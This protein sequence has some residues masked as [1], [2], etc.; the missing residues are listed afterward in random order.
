MSEYLHAWHMIT[1]MCEFN[2]PPT[3]AALPFLFV[4]QLKQLLVSLATLVLQVGF[5]LSATHVRM[6]GHFTLQAECS[7][8]SITFY[9]SKGS[10]MWMCRTRWSQD[11]ATGFGFTEQRRAVLERT[12]EAFRNWNGCFY[13]SPWQN[14]Q[15]LRVQKKRQLGEGNSTPAI[16]VR[17]GNVRLT[18]QYLR[19]RVPWDACRA[20]LMS[21]SWV[22]M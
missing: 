9:T 14:F 16:A 1:T 5:I 4:S 19:L 11:M 2:D 6:P 13:L 22:T 7:V 10:W 17:T 20:E 15:H 18:I 12:I 3:P 8:A 21:T